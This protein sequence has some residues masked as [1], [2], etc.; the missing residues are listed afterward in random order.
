[1]AMTDGEMFIVRLRSGSLSAAVIA[2][3]LSLAMR[4]KRGV[5]ISGRQR[6]VMWL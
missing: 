5:R 2:Q 3:W 4:V 6:I 1:M